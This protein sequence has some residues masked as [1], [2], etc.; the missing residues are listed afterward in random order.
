MQA[1]RSTGGHVCRIRPLF[2]DTDPAGVV[3]YGTYLRYLEEARTQAVE[4]AGLSVATVYDEGVLLPV[5]HVSIDYQ[6]PAQFGCVVCITTEVT[7]IRRVRF[8]L[9]HRL[10][11]EQTGRA[12]ARATVWLATVA[13]DSRKPVRLP[14]AM[15]EALT[16]LMVRADRGADDSAVRE[17]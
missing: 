4:A 3:Y 9:D 15:S 14:T 7:E 8:R 16:A 12:I 11:D 10:Y 2:A 6:S 13:R 17:R 1:A 5:T